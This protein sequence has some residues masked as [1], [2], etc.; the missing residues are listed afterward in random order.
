MR[1]YGRRLVTNILERR[2]L[3]LKSYTSFC[4]LILQPSKTRC[5]YSTAFIKLTQHTKEAERIFNLGVSWHQ[6]SLN[7]QIKNKTLYRIYCSK[8]SKETIVS[9][10][11]F[12]QIYSKEMS[13]HSLYIFEDLCKSCRVKIITDRACNLLS[14]SARKV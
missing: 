11:L 10:D 5:C 9:P 4:K 13:Q 8:N 3:H 1:K 7:R 2:P 6:N 12:L 14:K